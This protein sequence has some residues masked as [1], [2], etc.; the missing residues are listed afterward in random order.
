MDVAGWLA[1]LVAGGG[2]LGWLGWLAWLA[3]WQVGGLIIYLKI[4]FQNMAVPF[5]LVCFSDVAFLGV[6]DQ[7]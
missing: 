1:G 3:G 7:I 2:G 4:R 6:Y 5:V